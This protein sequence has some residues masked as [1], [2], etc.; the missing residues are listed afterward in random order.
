MKEEATWDPQSIGIST[1]HLALINPC[2]ESADMSYNLDS[3]C[4]HSLLHVTMYRL[5]YTAWE[6][7][8]NESCRLL[9]SCIV[10]SIFPT[11]PMKA[12]QEPVVS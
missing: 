4:I 3:N 8:V 9:E 5:I 7:G 12:V 6:G 10:T 11:H 1:P 2:R